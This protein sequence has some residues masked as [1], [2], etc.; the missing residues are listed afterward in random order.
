M[1]ATHLH[2]TAT[3]TWPRPHRPVPRP[4]A[5]SSLRLSLAMRLV[6]T[7]VLALTGLLGSGPAQA[8][9]P[10]PLVASLDP[11]R[12]QGVWFEITK[13]PNFF[14][15]RCLSDTR[16]T[17]A[18]RPDGQIDVINRCRTGGSPEAPEF[19][20]AA[21]LARPLD[22]TRARLQVSFLPQS[23]RWLPLG[24]GDY[25]VIALDPDYRWAMIGEPG[26]D[27][28]W[29]LAR[30]PR[31]PADVLSALIDRARLLGFPVER[32]Q[33]TAHHDAGAR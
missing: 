5:A 27:Y 13:L 10:L 9:E 31:L 2:A 12:Y 30:E 26:R 18:L 25:Q 7:L 23:L 24:W 21:G 32:L 29:I 17:Y 16:A 6:L 28:L 4:C 33:P 19:D 20:T 8:R 15:R 14:Q 1:H 3:P 22:S 11:V